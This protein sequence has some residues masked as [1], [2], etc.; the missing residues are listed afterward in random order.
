MDEAARFTVGQWVK[1]W[2]GEDRLVSTIRY[3]DN[4]SPHWRVKAV[5]ADNMDIYSE[6]CQD[7]FRAGA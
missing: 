4:S 6:G 7:Y 1:D 3:I 5:K 2:K